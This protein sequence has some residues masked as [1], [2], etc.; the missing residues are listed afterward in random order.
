MPEWVFGSFSGLTIL[1]FALL[2]ICAAYALAAGSVKQTTSFRPY[3][4]LMGLCVP[5]SWLPNIVTLIGWELMA[6]A[7]VSWFLFLSLLFA[8]LASIT[9]KLILR[10]CVVGSAFFLPT[11]PRPLRGLRW[12]DRLRFAETPFP[13]NCLRGYEA[14]PE[15]GLARD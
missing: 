6:D 4:V 14:R 15:A 7:I 5:A 12:E 13:P 9:A 11:R 10:R 1:S 3:L 8:L 2:A